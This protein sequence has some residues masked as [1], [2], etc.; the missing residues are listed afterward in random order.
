MI[1]EVS[2]DGLYSAYMPS[3]EYNFGLAGYGDT[4]QEA[5]DDFYAA[6]S[7]MKE[8]EEADGRTFPDLQFQFEHAVGYA[9]PESASY[10][11]AEDSE[12]YNEDKKEAKQ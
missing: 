7:E 11:V 3:D 1:I 4:E 12:G 9:F 6:V 10:F 5:I 8:L 2:A